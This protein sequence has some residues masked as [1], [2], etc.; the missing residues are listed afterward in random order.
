MYLDKILLGTS[1]Y[2]HFDLLK[3][4]DTLKIIHLAFDEMHELYEKKTSRFLVTHKQLIN[5]VW[6]TALSKVRTFKK[7][8]Q[9]LPVDVKTYI[10]AK[11][12][13]L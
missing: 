10:T 5:R 11:Y 12:V 8:I 6:V 1:V 3:E 2:C 7:P 13:V 9:P 4:T